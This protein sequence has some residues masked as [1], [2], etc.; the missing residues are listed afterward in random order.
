MTRLS[1]RGLPTGAML[2]GATVCACNAAPTLSATP[3]VRV[4]HRMTQGDRWVGNDGP[5]HTGVG[6]DLRWHPWAES[7]GFVQGMAFGLEESIMP[8][9]K[10]TYQGRRESLLVGW[11][12]T[13]RRP[14]SGF[15]FGGEITLV[16]I[17]WSRI[18]YESE[19]ESAIALGA[20]TAAMLKLPCLSNECGDAL[21][22]Y[23]SLLVLELG[24]NIF[25]PLVREDSPPW[26][27]EGMA[28]LAY[29]FDFSLLP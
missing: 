12:Y 19:V 3:G 6:A 18:Y 14:G 29:R 16:P 23:R 8:V 13:P 17:G 9:L 5:T 20:R 11:G 27:G 2:L 10:H 25:Y 7:S 4:G 26:L 15:E 22:A 24:W 28:T 1:R 21:W